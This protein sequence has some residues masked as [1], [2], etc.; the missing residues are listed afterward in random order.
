[1][2]QEQLRLQGLEAE[3]ESLQRLL[4]F[5]PPSPLAT[6]AASVLYFDLTSAVRSLIVDTGSFR[7]RPG[8]PVLNEQGLVGR[9]IAVSGSFAKVQLL[10]DRAFH[11]AVELSESRRQGIARGDGRYGLYVDYVS[12]TAPVS[13]KETV[14]TAGTDGIFPRAIP[15]GRVIEVSPASEHFHAIRVQPFV[16]LLRLRGV[17]VVENPDWAAL[18]ESSGP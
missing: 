2:R 15:V 7:A 5:S 13:E 18:F 10:T 12:R 9:V 6:H 17:L 1:L 16:D 11:A 4:K 14:L 8:F 3:L